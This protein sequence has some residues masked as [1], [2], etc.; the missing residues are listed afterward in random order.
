MYTGGAGCQRPGL[1]DNPLLV[2]YLRI[3]SR[4]GALGGVPHGCHGRI[5]GRKTT[6]VGAAEG[7]SSV[8]RKEQEVSWPNPPETSRLRGPSR[9]AAPTRPPRRQPSRRLPPL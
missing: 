2:L 8:S 9:P 1:D 7:P 5:S 3:F 4:G 6:F